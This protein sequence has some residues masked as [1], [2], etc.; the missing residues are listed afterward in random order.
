MKH[1]QHSQIAS[2]T[3]TQDTL[4]KLRTALKKRVNNILSAR[5]IS[6]ANE[7]LAGEKKLDEVLPVP[8]DELVRIELRVIVAQIR[9]LNRSIR[10]LETTIAAEGAKLERH[11]N[12]NSIK[13]I[14]KIT[15]S[16]LLSVIDDVN[17]SPHEHQLASCLGILAF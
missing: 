11:K 7:A 1:K 3:Q 16:I 5:G 4:V 9:S 14:G 6:V 2:L 8:F 17:D 15:G 12:L 10:E 13:G